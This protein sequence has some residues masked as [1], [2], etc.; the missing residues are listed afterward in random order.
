MT[1]VYNPI[2]NMIVNLESFASNIN[3]EFKTSISEVLSSLEL[4]K[5]TGEFEEANDNAIRSTKRLNNIL[6]VL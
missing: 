1:I 4:A 5:M 2:K 6:D 3:H